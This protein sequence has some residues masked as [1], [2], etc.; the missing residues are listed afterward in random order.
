[1]S[2][3]ATWLVLGGGEHEDGCAIYAE[4]PPGS[5]TLEFSGRPCSC[6]TPRAPLVYEGSHVLPADTDRRGGEVQVAAIP[7]FIERD[8][9]VDARGSG[10]KDWLRLSVAS[11]A[12]S[13]MRKGEPYVP[14][15]RATVVLTRPLVEELRD[16][17]TLWLER[18][19]CTDG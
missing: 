10:L 7:D 14:G 8:G 4:E 2:I 17:L 15:G 18:E 6:G 16:T 9:R 3:Y 19:E 13:L 11:D 1:M 12:S 5:G